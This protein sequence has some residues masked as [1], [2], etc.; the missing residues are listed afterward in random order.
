MGV[1]LEQK[2]TEQR[3]DK[4]QRKNDTKRYSLR[5]SVTRGGTAFRHSTRVP[6]AEDPGEIEAGHIETYRTEESHVSKTQNTQTNIN[7]RDKPLAR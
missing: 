5:P 3:I 7:K 1:T 2:H 4:K 6:D